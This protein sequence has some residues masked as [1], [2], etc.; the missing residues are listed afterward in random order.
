MKK[1]VAFTLILLLAFSSVSFAAVS[2]SKRS[3]SPSR[4]STG[5]TSVTP[6]TPKAS[7]DSGYKPSAPSSSYSDK[8]PA[9][10]AKP[11][12]TQPAPQQTNQGG[13]WRTAGLFGS[14]MLLGGMLSSMFGFGNMGFM[15]NLLGML[16]NV[17]ALVA[18]FAAIRWVWNRF[19]NK[20]KD[21]DERRHF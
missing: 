9:T 2:G 5:T 11:G 12:V 6:S 7:P 4:P 18:I 13:F 21:K 14:G 3:S 15:A 20:D 16:F 10:Q 1:I 19:R 8:A 17:I